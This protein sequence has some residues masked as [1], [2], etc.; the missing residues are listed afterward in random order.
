MKPGEQETSPAGYDLIRQHEG[1]RLQAYKDPVGLWT[2]GYGHLIGKKLTGTRELNLAAAENLLEFDIKTAERAVNDHVLA[3]LTQCQFDALVS[4][5]FNLGEGR[6]IK[7]TMLRVLNDG[8]YDGAAREMERWC[9]GRVNRKI[10]ELP[11]LVKRRKEE[12][13][14]FM[15][16]HA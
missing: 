2:I 5:V 14:L 6:L 7:S 13:A 1:L 10:V 16:D 9:K 11:G 3:P 15:S 12:A 8:D 4:W